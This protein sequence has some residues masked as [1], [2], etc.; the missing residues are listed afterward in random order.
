MEIICPHKD[1]HSQK[2]L[3]SGNNSNIHQQLNGKTDC[4]MSRKWNT[5]QQQKGINYLLKDA[6][7]PPIYE[8]LEGS[9][10]VNLTLR[11]I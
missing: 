4:G 2:W 7:G 11:G 10:T 5:S 9:K 3:K 6:T 8:P 1:F